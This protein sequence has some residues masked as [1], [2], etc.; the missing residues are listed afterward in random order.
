MLESSFQVRKA[1]GL[2]SED[3]QGMA[4]SSAFVPSSPAQ[5]DRLA[6]DLRKSHALNDPGHLDFD[7]LVAR[8]HQHIEAM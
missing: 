1:Q 7:A 6:L 8:I 4:R 2:W 3:G 5:L